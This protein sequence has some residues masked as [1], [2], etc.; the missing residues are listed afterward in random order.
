MLSPC[1]RLPQRGLGNNDKR[2]TRSRTRFSRGLLNFVFGLFLF[3]DRR[4]VLGTL[5][6]RWLLLVALVANDALALLVVHRLRSRM[7]NRP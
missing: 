3:F 2:L 5:L 6:I 7:Q 4:H 1:E